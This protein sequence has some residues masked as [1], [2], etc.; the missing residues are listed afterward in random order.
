MLLLGQA[1]EL[2]ALSLLVAPLTWEH[3]YLFALPLVLWVIGVSGRTRPVCVIL[4]L[5]LC[6]GI[7]T[8][9]LFPFSFHRIAGL[10]LLL[11][12]TPPGAFPDFKGWPELEMEYENT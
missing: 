4:G 7:P 9:D 8:F 5:V 3:H 2:L 1:A 6:H 11:V 12:I 10:I